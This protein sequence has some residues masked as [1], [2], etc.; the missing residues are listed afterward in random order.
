MDI[1]QLVAL[2]ENEKTWKE[3]NFYKKQ[4]AQENTE[5]VEDLLNDLNE[6]IHGKHP[7]MARLGAVRLLKNC[8]EAG[9][10]YFNFMVQEGDFLDKLADYTKVK[11]STNIFSNKP[12]KREQQISL[13]L[14]TYIVEGFLVWANWFP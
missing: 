9:Q 5:I 4:L 7:P 13:T 10:E 8:L 11:T 6:I 3:T 1:K 12:D 14:Y 2:L